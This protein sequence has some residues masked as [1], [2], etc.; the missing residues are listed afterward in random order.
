MRIKQK[1]IDSYNIQ[2]STTKRFS[3]VLI[4]A[5]QQPT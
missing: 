1:G 4:I 2:Q 5:N 3:S